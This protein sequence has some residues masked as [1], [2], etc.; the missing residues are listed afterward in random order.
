MVSRVHHLE[1]R[2]ATLRGRRE[3]ACSLWPEGCSVFRLESESASRGDGVGT[4]NSL[5]C[6]ACDCAG[7]ATIAVLRTDEGAGRPG[8]TRR[9][10]RSSGT[11]KTGRSSLTFF[12]LL[13]T[14]NERQ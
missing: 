11:F 1:I 5:V 7:A 10:R 3:E 4:E 13:P 6:L 9:T 14:S 12:G 2:G 8:R